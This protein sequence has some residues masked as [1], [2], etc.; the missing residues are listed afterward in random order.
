MLSAYNKLAVPGAAAIQT[1]Y[2]EPHLSPVPLQNVI[3]E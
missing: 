2:D 1:T 3:A